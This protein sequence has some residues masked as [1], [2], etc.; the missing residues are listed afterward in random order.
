MLTFLALLAAQATTPPPP[1]VP[2]DCSDAAHRAFDFFVGD[3]EV[4]DRQSGKIVATSRIERILGGCAIKESYD[5]NIGPDGTATDYRGTSYTAFNVRA[6][7]RQFYVDSSGAAAA[8]TGGIV[9]GAMV[10]TATNGVA[11]NR[12]TIAPQPDGSVRQ[13]G[14]V[15]LDGGR[16]W[17]SPGYDFT[18]RR[19]A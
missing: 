2:I 17:A 16:T 3:W 8:Y 18:Y 10:L 4:T 1:P 6:G 14:M 7:W 12:M 9:D 13:T 15:S 11:T 5:Q 19:K